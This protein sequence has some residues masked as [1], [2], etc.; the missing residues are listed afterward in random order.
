MHPGAGLL[1][2]RKQENKARYFS[3]RQSVNCQITW[4]V[5]LA[6]GKHY[7]RL[8]TTEEVS[9]LHAWLESTMFSAFV[10]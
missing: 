8:L 7:E 3:F 6:D 1:E 5:T 10:S 2:I 9:Q 4:L